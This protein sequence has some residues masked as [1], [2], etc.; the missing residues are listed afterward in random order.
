M[1]PKEESPDFTDLRR[2]AGEPVAWRWKWEGT[3]SWN[4]SPVRPH[5]EDKTDIEPIYSEAYVL[6]LI[7]EV[8][9]M[10]AALAPFA[11]FSE[12]Y[13]DADGDIEVGAASAFDPQ[14]PVYIRDFH[15]AHAAIGR[16]P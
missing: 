13:P 10:R 11:R 1:T 7:A 8:E 9:T 12:V 6:S 14:C 3:A 2:L 5:Q 16:K 15:R 4:L